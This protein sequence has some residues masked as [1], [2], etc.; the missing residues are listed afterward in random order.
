MWVCVQQ[1]LV[2]L[3]GRSVFGQPE[4]TNLAR[5]SV[6]GPLTYQNQ[7]GLAPKHQPNLDASPSHRCPILSSSNGPHHGTLPVDDKLST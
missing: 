6:R 7:T 3:V 2:T 4:A 5:L 1:P